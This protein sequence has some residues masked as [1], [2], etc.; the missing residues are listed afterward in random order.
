MHQ[1]KVGQVWETRHQRPVRIEAVY[2]DGVR[3]RDSITGHGYT[4]TLLGLRREGHSSYWD[5][6]RLVGSDDTRVE[7]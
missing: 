7:K 5:L 3:V 2:G 1:F 6:T 4:T